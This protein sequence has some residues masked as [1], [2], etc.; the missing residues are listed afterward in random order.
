VVLSSQHRFLENLGCQLQSS[1]YLTCPADGT[2]TI[3]ESVV[4]AISKK[5]VAGVDTRAMAIASVTHGNDHLELS[6]DTTI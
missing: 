6:R 3:G 5:S 1:L 4:G 2:A